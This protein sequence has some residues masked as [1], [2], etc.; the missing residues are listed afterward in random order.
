M[1]NNSWACSCAGLGSPSGNVR[2]A[3]AVFRGRVLSIEG[4]G[5]AR[6]RVRFEVLASWKGPVDRELTV[7]TGSGYGDCG[8]NFESD[9]EYVVYAYPPR[10]AKQPT[11]AL[12]TNDCTRTNQIED[13]D[14]DLKYLEAGSTRIEGKVRHF[15][16]GFLSCASVPEGM[17]PTALL[18]LV[19]LASRRMRRFS[20]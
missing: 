5:F 18:A 11:D 13:A 17:V 8:F 12:E 3:N 16:P 10:D 7:E 19:A 20:A 1:P 15:S 6:R 9:R 4:S 14:D 2:H